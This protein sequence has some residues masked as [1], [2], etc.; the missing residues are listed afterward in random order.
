MNERSSIRPGRVKPQRTVTG[1]TALC[2]MLSGAQAA[3]GAPTLLPIPTIAGGGGATWTNIE[4]T[5]CGGTTTAL[6]IRDASLGTLVDAYD[7]ALC[8]LVD[9]VEYAGPATVDQTGS[10]V[11]S[12]GP[13]LSGAVTTNYQFHFMPSR[14]AVRVLASFTNSSANPATIPIVFESNL[15]TDSA[16]VVAASSSGD[17]ALTVA[18]HWFVSNGQAADPTL[19]HVLAG[20]GSPLVVPGVAGLGQTSAGA[21]VP[22]SLTG[23]WCA[24]YTVTIPAGATRRLMLV[25]ELTA[26]G[27]AGSAVGGLYNN[28][29]TVPADLFTGLSVDTMRE[30]VNWDLFGA[31]SLTPATIPRGTPSTMT[32]TGRGFSPGMTVDMGVDV[33]TGPVTVSSPTTATFVATAAQLAALGARNVTVSVA[34]R[35]LVCPSCY[36]VATPDGPPLTAAVTLLQRTARR[37]VQNALLLSLSE[38]STV[39]VRVEQIRQGRRRGGV[40]RP[41]ALTGPRCTAFTVRGNLSKLLEPGASVAMVLPARIGGKV[42]PAGRYRLTVT[43]TDDEGN[44]SVPRR[45]NLLVTR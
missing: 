41:T 12:G 15:G 11:T 35:S 29:A 34:G 43:A 5:G 6:G 19:T 14:S 7:S 25:D 21:C 38:R 30:I 45:L 13:V 23:A 9:G 4:A 16:T 42:L 32:L 17:A 26:D 24:R 10:T 44:V 2:L 40:C 18:D 27:P 37:G 1:V 36:F 8:M 33:T 28:Q 31:T 3:M 22:G 20:P 39:R